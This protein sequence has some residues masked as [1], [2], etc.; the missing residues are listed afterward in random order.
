[1]I[2]GDESYYTGFY[3]LSFHGS[4]NWNIAVVAPEDDFLQLA[5]ERI[6]WIAAVALGLVIIVAAASLWVGN[7]I[8][9]PIVGITDDIEHIG[10]ME[11][12]E[13]EPPSSIVREITTLG[14][15]VERMKSELR[16]MERYIPSE[17]ARGLVA[18]GTEATLSVERRELGIFFSDIEGFTGISERMDPIDLVAELREYFDAMTEL[19]RN[20]GTI[21]KFIGDAV[22]ALFN[23][24]IR[25][26]HFAAE[27]C[28]AAID[29][30]ARLAVLAEVSGPCRE[31]P[32]PDADRLGVGRGP[33]G[34]HRLHKSVRLHGAGRPGERR[35]PLRGG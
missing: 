20:G 16:S 15:S 24:P 31:G 28:N 34:E 13:R 3:D 26:E 9:R 12:A 18:K 14:Q 29:C 10:H 35:R 8:A 6:A 7:R 21:D 30:Q 23:A 5:E 1:M 2:K 4:L 11:F 32:L 19:E 17:V 25:R 27:L 22:M 33:C